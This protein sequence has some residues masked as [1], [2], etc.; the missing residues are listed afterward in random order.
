MRRA[1]TDIGGEIDEGVAADLWERALRAVE[2]AWDA[3]LARRPAREPVARP[4]RLAEIAVG[5]HAV[6]TE[7][8]E[9]HDVD[10]AE[11]GV[12]AVVARDVETGDRGAGELLRGGFGLGSGEGEHR[13]VV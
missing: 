10:D 4:D 13:P 11:T 7:R 1:A 6:R 8:D 5:P 3:E 2:V 9:R 12:D